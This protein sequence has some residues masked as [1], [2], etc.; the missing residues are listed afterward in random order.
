MIFDSLQ[1]DFTI[2]IRCTEMVSLTAGISPE[3]FSAS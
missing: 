3:L 1:E 2:S